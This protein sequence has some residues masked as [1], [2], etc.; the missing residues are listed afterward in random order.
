MRQTPYQRMVQRTPL[1]AMLVVSLVALVA[2]GG[3]GTGSNNLIAVQVSSQ[4]GG[5]F[6]NNP[7]NP[8]ITITI[9]P[10]AL[11][12]DAN[13]TVDRV[14]A[15]PGTGANQ[16]AASS[17]YAV[18]IRGSGTVTL[19]EPLSI[20]I[21]VNPVPEHPQLGEI[22]VLEGASWN[23]LQS[24]FFKASGRSVVSL[25]TR[26]SGTFRAVHRSIQQATGPGVA[27]GFNV[28]MYETFGNEAFFGNVGLHTVLNNVSPANAVALGA[29]VDIDRVPASIA[30]FLSDPNV[31]AADKAAAL[32]DPATTRALV[33][34]GA[35][36]GVKGFYASN[37]PND[38]TLVR[39]GITCALCHVLVTPT[40]FPGVGT[41]PVGKLN[42]DGVPNTKI[43]VGAI[44]AFTPFATGA[45][46]S[47]VDLLNSWGP[48]RFDIRALPDNPLEDNVN[49]PTK[50][51]AL[52]NFIDLS[53]QGYL[54][55]WD[56][57][58]KDNG[59][60]NNAL[61][62]ITEVAYDLPMHSNGAFGTAAGTLPPELSVTPPADLLNALA[63]AET[64]TPG[65]DVV[66]LQKLLDVQTWMRSLASPK[67]GA[68]D[69]AKALQGF[70]LFHGK[71]NCVTCH[72]TA[73]LTG[74]GLFTDITATAPTGGLAGGVR[75]PGLR[76]I[77]RT[78]PYFHDHSAR[79]LDDVVARFVARGKQVPAL[80]AD[81]QKAV[82]EYL[83][84]L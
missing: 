83:K 6:T 59:T 50:I 26:T 75:I 24:N 69:E 63:Q 52:W 45:G 55:G 8:D 62:S 1:F 23:R 71:A 36:V 65:N 35:V 28:F 46:Q 84:S 42:I 72:R 54:I 56:G 61:A 64:D 70:R 7:N 44:L 27:T 60:T 40:S 38:T 51:P 31:P 14:D 34:A 67:P 74:P 15:P 4:N 81:E 39:A 21:R 20:E 66:P 57:L 9:P 43:D 48:G 3:G 37:D 30:A 25:T 41:L 18:S 47:V 82:V 22:A 77:S 80:T 32:Q 13:L 33:K 73:D 19:R 76:G 2:C 68:F 5:T 49:N 10:G 16:I 11:S 79:T 12:S 78:A 58:F 29:Q 17:A 53:S